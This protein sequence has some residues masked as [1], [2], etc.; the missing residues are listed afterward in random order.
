[1]SLYVEPMTDLARL[2]PVRHEDV[3]GTVL[4]GECV[5]LNLIT[6]RYYTLNTVGAF[7]WERCNGSHSVAQIVSCIPEQ[8]DVTSVQAQSDGLD[9][10]VQLRQEGLLHTERR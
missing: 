8:F 10:I 9:L 2:F 6:G 4:D 1:M 3:H 7:V 5:L